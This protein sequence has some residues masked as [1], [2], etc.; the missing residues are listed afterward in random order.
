M[1]AK[2]SR[3]EIESAGELY[4]WKGEAPP[5]HIER[6]ARLVHQKIK[7]ARLRNRRLSL[8]KAAVVAALN[9]ADEYRRLQDDHQNLVNLIE[10]EREK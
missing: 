8:L 9:I 3:V 1:P 6:G 4:V 2:E 10:A 5:E 7:E